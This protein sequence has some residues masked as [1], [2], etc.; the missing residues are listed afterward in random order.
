MN[1]YDTFWALEASKPTPDYHQDPNGES[2]KGYGGFLQEVRS[3]VNQI[4]NFHNMDDFAL[5]T[6][7]KFFWFEAN[8][9]KNQTD[10]KPDGSGTAI[11]ASDWRY[12]YDMSETDAVTKGRLENIHFINSTPVWALTRYINDSYEMKSFIARPRSKAVGAVDASLDNRP[13][14]MQ[15][16]NLQD[17]RFDGR[18]S[19][20]SGQFNRRIQQVH[21]LYREIGVRAG[22]LQPQ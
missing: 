1:G 9:E 15:H 5:A 21:E 10:Y 2:T 8:W 16:V 22:L 14:I 11:H 7:I 17:Y 12:L 6:G 19:D 3:N 13:S 18:K 20:H 4:V